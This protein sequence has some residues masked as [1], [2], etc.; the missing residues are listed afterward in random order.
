M[1]VSSNP[2]IDY[3]ECV[4]IGASS[5]KAAQARKLVANAVYPKGY[6]PGN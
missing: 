6:T 2:S 1:G 3:I 4:Y 5:S